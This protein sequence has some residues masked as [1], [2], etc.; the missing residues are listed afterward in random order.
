MK[1]WFVLLS[2]CFILSGCAKKVEI[3]QLGIVSG[4]G[5]D[6][7]DNGY[8]MTAQVVN[9][10]SVAGKQFNTLPVYSISAEGKTLFEAYRELSTL[11]AKVLY[12]PH[13]SVI[14]ISEEIAKEGID[15]VLD[16]TLRNVMIRP[17]ISLTV[18]NNASAQNILHVLSSSEQIPIN[19]LDAISNLCIECTSRQ[20]SYNLYHVDS[21]VNSKGTNVVLN[22][23]AVEGEDVEEG[24]YV[25]NILEVDSPTKIQLNSLAAFKEDKLVGYLDSDEA[26]YYNV[27]V[28]LA[29]RYVVYTMIDNQYEVTFEGHETKVDIEPDMDTKKVKV[30]CETKGILMENDYPINLLEPSN[31]DKMQSYLENQLK[32]NLEN[33]I[34]KTQYEF[35]SD[36]LGVGSK[37]HQKDPKT[38]SQLEAYWEEIYPT[39]D[40]EVE[41]KVEIKSVGEIANSKE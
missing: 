37:I 12:L 16:F 32:L 17:N 30:N 11:T 8:L 22:S 5:I 39:L 27:L 26:E 20:V 31:V 18:A 2:M 10:S 40:F 35:G 29:K 4:V 21:M 14:V 7:T 36:I 25:D 13:I 19:Q 15:P 41:V 1:R 33:V 38:W 28:D 34:S 6:K 24:E 23:V 3:S 9:P